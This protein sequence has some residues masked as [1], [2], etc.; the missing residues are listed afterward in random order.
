MNLKEN[1]LEKEKWKG[2]EE[3]LGK[4]KCGTCGTKDNSEEDSDSENED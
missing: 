4:N 2:K 3:L 1:I